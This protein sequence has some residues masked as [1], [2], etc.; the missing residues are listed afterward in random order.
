MEATWWL[1]LLGPRGHREWDG[2]GESALGT[3]LLTRVTGRGKS[4]HSVW[5]A[6]GPSFWNC[7][8]GRGPGTAGTSLRPADWLSLQQCC[9]APWPVSVL[10]VLPPGELPTVSS[11][12]RIWAASCG[13]SGGSCCPMGTSGQ[14][15]VG[16]PAAAPK[17]GPGVTVQPHLA[18][19]TLRQFPIHRGCETGP[20]S[21]PR[22]LD[23]GHSVGQCCSRTRGVL[24]VTLPWPPWP[25]AAWGARVR[26]EE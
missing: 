20:S 12:T 9:A 3:A 11:W 10:G 18:P 15:Q 5:E 2:R 8:E 1:C 25:H 4:W 23:L 24:A 17:W 6:S 22:L 16:L 21:W 26:P 19:A 7:Q 13:C 14:P